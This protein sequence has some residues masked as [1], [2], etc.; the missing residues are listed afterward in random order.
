M[1]ALAAAAAAVWLFAGALIAQ[2][3]DGDYIAYIGSYTNTTAKGIY[4]ARFNSK[5]GALSPLELVAEDTYPAQLWGTPNGRFLY[6][7]N[8]QGTETAPGD[9][10]TAYAIDRRT[11]RLT[12]LNKV[13]CGGGGPNQVVVDPSGK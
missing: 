8:W 6:A 11:G 5:T 3:P 2:T 7:A 9:T 10:I 4:A 1:R 12:L 13:N